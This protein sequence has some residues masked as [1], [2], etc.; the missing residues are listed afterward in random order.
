MVAAPAAIAVSLIA[1]TAIGYLYV[2]YQWFRSVGFEGVFTTILWT[3]IWLSLA[4]GVLAGAILY[5]NLRLARRKSR[6][7][8]TLVLGE[9]ALSEIDV[10]KTATRLVLPVS[11]GLGLAMGV[12]ASQSWSLWLQLVNAS[13]FQVND[14]LFGRD[15]GFYIFQL[16]ALEA[17]CTLLQ[18]VVGVTLLATAGM[19][20]AHGGLNIDGRIPR[21]NK[22]T[23]LHV[24]ILAAL[25][26]VVFAFKAWIA[27]ANLLYSSLG[28][29]SGA[30]YADA[31]A[32]LPALRVEIALS[33]VGAILILSFAK[34]QRLMLPAI[35]VGLYL[36]V[37]LLGVSLYP[38]LVHSI[39]VVP[40]EAEREA[41]FIRHNIEAT[42]AAYGLGA[43]E[44]RELGGDLSLDSEDIERN[45]ATTDNIRL[46]DHDLLLDT[47]A[48]IQ[49]IRT[50]YHFTSVH[51]DRYVID[52]ALRQTMLSARELSTESLPSRTWVNERFIFTHG[53]GITL[54]PVNM[55]T[56]EG[57]PEL[58]IQDIP[59]NSELETLSVTRPAIY[60]GEM[61]NDYVFVN[62]PSREFDYPS[63]EDNIYTQY[64]G[65]AGVRLGNLFMRFAAA[66]RLG[67]IK[68]LLSDDIGSESRVLLYRNIRQRV[69][70]IAP[71]L[72]F[73]EDPYMVVRNNGQLVW[74]QDAYTVTNRYPYSQPSGGINYISNSVKIVI[75]AYD[76]AVTFYIADEDD[77]LLRTWRRAFPGTFTA[78]SEMPDDLR[79]HLRYPE[80]IFRIQTEMYAIYHMDRPGLLYNREDQWEIPSIG[81]GESVQRMVPYYTIMRLPGEE[82][83]EFIQMLPFT[84][85]RKANL[86]AWMVA[87]M[88]GERLGELVAYRFPR[89]RLVF[90][91]QQ[92]MSRINQ[93][94]D[95]SRQISLWDQRGSEAILGT[96]LIV[97]IEESMI[98]VCPLY[99][100]S[101]GGRIPE[102]KRVI[103]VYQNQIA[104]MPTLD[105][106]LAT[107]FGG[108][109]SEERVADA[110][111]E[112]EGEP[113]PESSEQPDTES[114][115]PV[116]TTD[117]VSS[118][119]Q[120]PAMQAR[121]RYE[122]AVAAQR[123]GDWAAYGEELRQLGELL[124]A[125]APP[126]STE[127]SET[128]EPTEPA[129]E[130][131]PEE[132]AEPEAAEPADEVPSAP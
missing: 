101:S 128:P 98:Y 129:P 97:P 122:R 59:P 43:V 22:S 39:S 118:E 8:G 44:D 111:A 96:L 28:P 14:P 23:R 24:C 67:S 52:G 110:G 55:A 85:M 36:G 64:E 87:R 95:I 33:L 53:Y 125:M 34:W 56:D 66:V 79:T 62:T 92:I 63:G 40:N 57:L 31:H 83:A 104:M 91:P 115:T 88:D 18:W 32:T 82:E 132:P 89:D 113:V 100:R 60:F 5:G 112:E 49:E 116:A 74:V 65:D 93:D 107:L 84:P 103:V 38:S 30:S 35:A 114:G 119:D 15:V 17:L 9:T 48:Q 29:V 69:E 102:L 123:R 27:S 12:G 19:Y 108:A 99:L 94:A 117:E 131:E 73:D 68:V 120:S 78:M 81:H 126:E 7:N 26:F 130:T 3:R 72:R 71:F 86:A 42:R 13:E 6:G 61:S 1:L 2:D 16:P 10:G 41:P 70:R 20:I 50:Y 21:L 46:W 105:E 54:G 77:P 124:Q 80:D 11:I 109:S 90:G 121:R 4:V 47:F 37:E 51:N 76:G 75:D 127:P 58:F 106:A 45:R 25:L